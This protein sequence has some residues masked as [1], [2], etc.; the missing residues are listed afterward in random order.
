MLYKMEKKIQ[1]STQCNLLMLFNKAL[2][3]ISEKLLNELNITPYFVGWDDGEF[4]IPNKYP[5][6]FFQNIRETWEKD[7]QI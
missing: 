3:E 1:K 2:L 5:E 7:F 6:C 4:N